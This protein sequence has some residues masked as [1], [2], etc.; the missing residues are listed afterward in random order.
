MSG[1]NK[2]IAV[3]FD[4]TLATYKFPEIGEPIHFSKN[5]QN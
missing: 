3:D 2:I 5:D 1:K 4:G